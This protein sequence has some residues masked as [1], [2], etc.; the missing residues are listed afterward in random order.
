MRASQASRDGL[1]GRRD[2]RGLARIGVAVQHRLLDRRP[3]RSGGRLGE[4][5]RRLR[6][7]HQQAA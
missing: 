1:D 5:P 6:I 4:L 7:Q 3:R 2:H